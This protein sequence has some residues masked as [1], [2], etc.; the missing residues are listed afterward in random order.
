MYLKVLK[1][2]GCKFLILYLNTD[3]FLN[4]SLGSKIKNASKVISWSKKYHI[5]GLK[6]G[7]NPINYVCSIG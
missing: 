6:N 4:Q 7:R 2:F 3:F 5:V 1:M